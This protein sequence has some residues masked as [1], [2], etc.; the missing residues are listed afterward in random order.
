MQKMERDAREIAEKKRVQALVADVVSDF[1]SR[2]EA[3]RNLE[4]AWLLNMRFL[5]G[6]QYCGIG[7]NG[8]IVSED[9]KFY[10]QTRRVY[11]RIAPII[12]A[13]MIKLN[14]TSPGLKVSATF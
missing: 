13:R 3:R 7:A 6:E 9:Q 12:D 8:G 11:N 5:A 1:E 2:R 14:K 4:D 10:W